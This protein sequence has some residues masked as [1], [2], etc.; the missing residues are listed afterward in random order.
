MKR[1]K[2]AAIHSRLKNVLTVPASS[3]DGSQAFR[4]QKE[5]VTDLKT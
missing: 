2:V 3:S 1:G 5:Q 4:V